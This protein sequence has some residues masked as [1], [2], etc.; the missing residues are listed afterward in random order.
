MDFSKLQIILLCICG[1]AVAA[2]VVLVI[3]SKKR[4]EKIGVLK[5]AFP[6]Q[7]PFFLL[8][9]VVVGT[10]VFAGAG[11]LNYRRDCLDYIED[12]KARGVSACAERY[13]TTEEELLSGVEVIGEMTY[14]EIYVDRETEQSAEYARQALTRAFMNFVTAITFAVLLF[15][16]CGVRITK[17]G[18]MYFIDLKP[19]K[20]TA[21]LGGG[22]IRFYLDRAEHAFLTLPCSDENEER[23][24]DFIIRK[25]KPA[26]PQPEDYSADDYLKEITK[27]K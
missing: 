7:M 1:A 24:S 10:F 26:V 4:A 23:Y 8:S 12:M 25:S 21:K 2:E 6:V 5:T 19:R 16:Q 20:T 15:T 3:V 27:G 13:N 22:K 9:I 11:N 18:A 17:K 14:A